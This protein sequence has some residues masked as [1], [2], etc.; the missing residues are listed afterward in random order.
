MNTLAGALERTVAALE[1]Y[2]ME[3]RLDR[4][5]DHA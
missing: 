2:L 1:P 5:P 3:F 4:R